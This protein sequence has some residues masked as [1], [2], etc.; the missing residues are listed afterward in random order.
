MIEPPKEQRWLR[1]LRGLALLSLT[2]L[3]V[4][5][6]VRAAEPEPGELEDLVPGGRVITREDIARIRAHNAWEAI[7]RS[8]THLVIDH[9]RDGTP[10][11]VSYRGVDSLLSSREILLVVDGNKVKNVEEELRAITAESILYIQI[12]TGREASQRWGSE[13][14]NGVIVIKTSAR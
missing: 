11:R 1:G 7:E 2:V 3:V 12:L 13:S 4:G 9:A 6:S 8:A 10:A 5:C 14:G